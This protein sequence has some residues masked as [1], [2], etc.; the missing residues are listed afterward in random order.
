M[1]YSSS[2][3]SNCQQEYSRHPFLLSADELFCLFDN[4]NTET[5]LSQLK[6]REAQEKYGPNKLEGEGVVQ[7]YSVLLKQIS[8][9]MILVWSLTSAFPLL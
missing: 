2:K 1:S 5:G 8:N 4:T 7:W 6:T 9:A 3:N